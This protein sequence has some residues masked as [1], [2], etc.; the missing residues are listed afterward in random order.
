MGAHELIDL[1]PRPEHLDPGRRTG[2]AGTRALLYSRLKGGLH[3]ARALD[4]DWDV[5][6]DGERFLLFLRRQSTELT[7]RVQPLGRLSSDRHV[8]EQSRW[9][10]V[11]GR[12]DRSGI[13]LGTS[14][15]LQS[16]ETGWKIS[17]GIVSRRILGCR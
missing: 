12:D 5:T 17:A 1:E 16:D 15:L 4:R 2:M 6:A 9:H 3:D 8:G 11:L 13:V 10:Y 14:G 7:R